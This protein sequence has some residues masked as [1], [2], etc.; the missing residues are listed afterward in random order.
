VFLK[1]DGTDA[2]FEVIRDEEGRY[3]FYD[4][5]GNYRHAENYRN[6]SS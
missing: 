5:E 6:C 4:Q 1:F 2:D 3:S